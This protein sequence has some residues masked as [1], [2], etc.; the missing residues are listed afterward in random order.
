MTFTIRPSSALCWSLYRYLDCWDY[1]GP[2]PWAWK[3]SG[4]CNNPQWSALQSN[5][6]P[7]SVCAIT[8]RNLTLPQAFTFDQSRYQMLV[9]LGTFCACFWCK[10]ELLYT[11]WHF[12]QI[13][14]MD[15]ILFSTF[16]LKGV[17]CTWRLL[18]CEKIVK[19]LFSFKNY[20][21]RSI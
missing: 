4:K 2:T 14:F 3:G 15:F 10:C 16:H 1:S 18:F 8:E 21:T 19:D 20:R 11:S 7:F 17:L 6:F 5:G 12:C 13:C 9:R